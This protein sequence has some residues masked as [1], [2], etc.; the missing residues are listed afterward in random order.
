[1]ALI[2]RGQ[3]APRVALAWLAY[4]GR[5]CTLLPDRPAWSLTPGTDRA[6]CTNRWTRGAPDSE[7]PLY[8]VPQKK[9]ESSFLQECRTCLAVEEPS[10]VPGLFAVILSVVV[11]LCY[12]ASLLFSFGVSR[13]IAQNL[14]AFLT[15]KDYLDVTPGWALPILH[16]F[17]GGLS[18][19]LPR[20]GRRSVAWYF[21]AGEGHKKRDPSRRDGRK[22]WVAGAVALRAVSPGPVAG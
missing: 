1:V 6:D 11:A 3:A 22:A 16:P 10:W 15:I 18:R 17:S 7:F 12:S 8:F 2:S 4:A 5:R 13:G 9:L 21:R 19:S 14:Q 20:R